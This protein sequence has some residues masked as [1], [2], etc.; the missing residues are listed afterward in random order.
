MP[1]NRQLFVKRRES[2]EARL[3]REK[4]KEKLEDNKKIQLTPPRYLNTKAKAEYRRIIPLLEELPIASLDKT[5]VESYCQ[6]YAT[7]RELQEDI[8]KNGDIIE[9]YYANGELKERKPNPS[10][11]EHLKVVR[12]IRFICSE[13]GMT[14]NSRMR[15]AEP[16]IEEDD[17]FKKMFDGSDN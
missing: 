2:T 5:M 7:A 1:R 17:P 4:V 15:L 13:L 8:K 10:I 16:T 11:H 3:F 9:V 6:L 12:E 14:I